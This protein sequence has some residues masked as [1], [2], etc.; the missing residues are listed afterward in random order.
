[1]KRIAQVIKLKPDQKSL[2][3]QL[4]ENVWKS[5]QQQIHASNI[6]NYSIFL[7][8]DLLF[9]YFDYAGDDFQADM[10]RMAEHEETKLWWTLTDPC[11]EPVPEAQPGEW[12]HTLTEIFHQD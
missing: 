2:Y 8:G 1:M 5:V 4:H 7:H 11:Q 3:L 10:D 9:S 12:W 6:R